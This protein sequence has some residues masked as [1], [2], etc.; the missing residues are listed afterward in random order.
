MMTNW[1][2][3]TVSLTDTFV[4]LCT[5]FWA[6]EVSKYKHQYVDIKLFQIQINFTHIFFVF[7]ASLCFFDCWVNKR[8]EIL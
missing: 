8:E 7:F 3:K 2:A 5:T 6:L 1:Y 4:L